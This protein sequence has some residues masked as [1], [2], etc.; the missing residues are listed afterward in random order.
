[1]SKPD[2]AERL[3]RTF[4][5]KYEQ[6][7]NERTESIVALL[8]KEFDGYMRV[9]ISVEDLINLIRSVKSVR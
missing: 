5:R 1:M 3:Q 7:A 8:Q 9:S 2:W 4:G 6:G